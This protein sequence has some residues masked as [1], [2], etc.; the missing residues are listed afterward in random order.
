MQEASLNSVIK[1]LSKKNHAIFDQDHKPFN[2][3]IVG[4]RAT[5]ITPNSFND[6][7]C[8]F[9][10]YKKNWSFLK[11][12]CTTDPGNY[13]LLNPGNVKGTAILK[14]G[15]YRGSHELGKHK[16]KYDALVQRKPV[17]VLRDADR[18][19][20][21]DFDNGIEEEGLFGINIHRANQ[22]KES[23]IVEKWSAGCTVINNPYEYQIFI[24]IC[25]SAKNI[26]GNS[27]TYTLI[28]QNNL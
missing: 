12:G 9:W 28:N 14:E 10:K 26:W 17:I 21:L 24:N 2:L 11:F 27:F 18:D 22:G 7:L 1:V 8:L 4:I 20:E 6:V 3:N 15:Q 25:E 19:K 13:W 5:D 23:S 16:G